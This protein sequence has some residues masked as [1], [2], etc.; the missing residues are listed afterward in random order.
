[1]SLILYLTMI[2]QYKEVLKL[3]SLWLIINI[4][5]GDTAIY[6]FMENQKHFHI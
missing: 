6:L 2:S 5:T 1:M 3:T 4:F